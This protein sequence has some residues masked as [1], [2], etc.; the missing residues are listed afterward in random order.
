MLEMSQEFDKLISNECICSSLK[1]RLTLQHDE[2]IQRVAN[3]LI[4]NVLPADIKNTIDYLEK[5]LKGPEIY[6][7]TIHNAKGDC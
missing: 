1:Q 2:V 5:T 4:D 3:N 6:T 7:P